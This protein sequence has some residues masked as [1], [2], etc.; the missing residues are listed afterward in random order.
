MGRLEKSK[1]KRFESIVGIVV[2]YPVEILVETFKWL[3]NEYNY[4]LLETSEYS[5]LKF[6]VIDTTR[7]RIKQKIGYLYISMR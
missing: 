4:S 5:C 7:N 6:S 2:E 1:L 3:R